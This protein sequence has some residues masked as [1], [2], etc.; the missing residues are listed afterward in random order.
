MGV[1]ITGYGFGGNVCTHLNRYTHSVSA[2][3][4]YH[5]G[6]IPA[7]PLGQPATYY[8]FEFNLWGLHKVIEGCL[9]YCTSSA[10]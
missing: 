6:A 4:L 7:I 9:P 2:V 3:H 10:Y 8:D 5:P 1:P